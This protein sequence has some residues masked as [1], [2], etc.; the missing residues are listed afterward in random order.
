MLFSHHTDEKPKL[1]HPRLIHI[2]FTRLVSGSPTRYAAR[3]CTIMGLNVLKARDL[4]SNF[5][6]AMKIYCKADSAGMQM[7]MKGHRANQN[8]L[9]NE[10]LARVM[11][12]FNAQA[13]QGAMALVGRL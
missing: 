13:G 5:W 8:Q 2:E 11:S 3:I 7:E 10:T 4:R 1:P 12:A 9:L 6:N